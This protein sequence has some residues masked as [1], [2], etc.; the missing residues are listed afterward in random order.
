MLK[1]AVPFVPSLSNLSL[2]A[3]KLPSAQ[4]ILLRRPEDPFKRVVLAES[5]LKMFVV[6]EEAIRVWRDGPVSKIFAFTEWYLI[7]RRHPKPRPSGGWS[8]IGV[9]LTGYC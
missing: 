2:V 6:R 5:R 9:V 7:I 3:A 4:E 1:E 8:E